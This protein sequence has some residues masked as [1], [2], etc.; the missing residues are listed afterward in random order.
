M[1]LSET[2]NR[3]VVCKADSS[4]IGSTADVYLTEI[5]EILYILTSRAREGKR[6][7]P[8]PRSRRLPMRL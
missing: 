3:D 7:C 4:L 8:S 1:K 6:F 5:V 2:L